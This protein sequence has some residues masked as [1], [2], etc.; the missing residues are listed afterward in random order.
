MNNRVV[1]LSIIILLFFFHKNLSAQLSV[2][3]VFSDNMV[4]QQ[5]SEVNIWGWA[6][7]GDTISITGSWN[8]TT[9]KT[10]CGNDNKWMAKLPTPAAKTDGTSYEI[11]ISGTNTI[12]LTNV[13][14]G[15]VWLLSGQSNMSMPLQGWGSSMPIEGSEEA[16]R[17][18]NFP[19]IRLLIVKRGNASNPQKD[20]PNKENS[21]WAQCSPNTAKWFSAVGFFFGREL[22]K[23]MNIPIGLVGSYWGGSS[24]E[25]W[26]KESSLDF[27]EDYAGGGPWHPKNQEDNHTPTVLYNAMIAPLVPFNFAG[28][29]W[30]QGET[31]VGRSE[32]HTELFPAM[33]EGWREELNKENL[34]FYFV[35][36]AP[37]GNS[38][39]DYLP[40]FW[41]TQ[42]NTLNLHD[43]EMASTIDV[44]DKNNIHPARKEPV[45]YR[46]AQKALAKVYGQSSLVYA[47]PRYK[48]HKIEGNKIRISFTNTGSGLKAA[49]ETLQQFEIAG[50]D[51]V[52]YSANAIISGNEILVSSSQVAVPKNVRYAW[53]N[54][55]TGSL[56]NNEDFPAPPF[57][58]NPADYIK[59]VNTSL[60]INT[61][62]INEGE[63]V[64]LK[65]TTIGGDTVQLNGNNVNSS[66]N[67]SDLPDTTITYTLKAINGDNT[68][69]KSKIVYVIPKELHSWAR[70]KTVKASSYKTQ[71]EPYFAVDENYETNWESNNRNNEWITID[72]G[73]IIPVNLIV[74]QWGANYGKAYKL[75]VSNDNQNWT[76]VF[77][78]LNGNGGTDF[79]NGLKASGR[80]V[81]MS[82]VARSGYKGYAL[83]EFKIYSTEQRKTGTLK[84]KNGLI[85]RGTPMTIG[86]E[87]GA[88]VKFALNKRNW[89]SI[90]NNGF[91]TIKVCWT[92]PWSKD[93]GNENMTVSEVLPLFD[94]CVQN[95]TET[96][97]N[98]I[99]SY[100]NPGAQQNFDTENK[101]ELEKEFWDSIAPRYKNNN[102]VYFELVNAPVSSIEGYTNT[103]FKKNILDIYKSVQTAAPEREIL[104]F[105]F[106]TI[107]DEI[108]AIVENYR[109]SIDWDKTSVAYQMYN[110]DYSDAVKTLMAY[111]RV[112]CTEWNYFHVAQEEGNQHIRRVD[113]FKQNSQ[114]LE[115][116]QSSWIDWHERNDTILN[117]LIDTLIFD[118]QI[119]NYWWGKPIPGLKVTGIKLFKDSVSV[120]TGKTKQLYA[121]ISPA[122]AG[123]QN[124]NWSSSNT[125]YVTVN[126]TGLIT[127]KATQAKT[128]TI[129]ANTIDGTF[130]AQCEITVI[131]HEKKG[132]YP[133]GVPHSIPGTI[134]ATHYDLGG[135]AVG[136][137]DFDQTN[138]GDGIRQEQ[139]VDTE[140]RVEEGSIGGIKTGEWL[141]YTVYVEETT[142]YNFEILF[143]S[144]G[145]YG[146]F[147]IEIDAEDKT[148]MVYVQPTGNYNVFRPTKIKNINL[149][150]GEHIIRIYF[151]FA[152][153]NMGTISIQKS[154][155]SA[156]IITR[157]AN[158]VKLFPNPTSNQLHISAPVIFN[159][160]SIKTITGQT[161]LQ[162]NFT[163][164]QTIGINQIEKGNYIL[165]LM[166]NDLTISKKLVKF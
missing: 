5:N 47:G 71:N 103:V 118:A 147:H 122:L 154:E 67:I 105:S 66:G 157:A 166:N 69:A 14:I 112:I 59:P 140:F 62:L 141:E 60:L 21:L 160:Y 93:H 13:L 36:L 79:I 53:S 107:S 11:T 64:Q 65:W 55:A 17:T 10:E 152:F 46:L 35:Q 33:I 161:V 151:D 27:V 127:A 56:Y 159:N 94:R 50:S 26:T 114:T 121:K 6:N 108:I 12:T 91:N 48:T 1:F 99:I 39:K 143:A 134:N 132:A 76:S 82:G 158:S 8:N 32:Q 16:I 63:P 43:T 37:Y 144:P 116:I 164:E 95:A 52:F 110:S 87:F 106:N 15:E 148:G 123:N 100:H 88:A 92:D 150:K 115:N 128:A 22:H 80:Y 30:Y 44:G 119:K 109:D 3:K 155:T 113:G 120:K 111:H 89:E 84:D 96:K 77:E 78:E 139:G 146:K 130:T 7:A 131:P 145:R 29:C 42:A 18:A 31:N 162:G 136:Y 19:N 83:K 137:H 2:A 72:L 156:A 124:I 129:T 75:Q 54:N 41:E 25:A 97:M 149:E 40:V 104:M 101:F 74:L 98:I 9:I 81:R 163:N 38:Y 133:K 45:G 117:E 34:P 73:E 49:T 135:E 86:K 57:R 28:V 153:F 4:L 20:I 165:I 23:K 61:N 58:T 102:Q 70:N 24:C 142:K 138:A 126:T 90:K 51:G 68:S 85:L 125:N